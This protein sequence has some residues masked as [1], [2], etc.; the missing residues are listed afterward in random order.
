MI[1]INAKTIPDAWFQLLYSIQGHGYRQDIQHGSFE[2]EQ[3]RIQ[4]PGAAVSIELPWVDMIQ[5]CRRGCQHL[6]QWI[7]SMTTS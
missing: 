4:Y 5:L 2:G 3:Y 6:R 1:Q 7:T